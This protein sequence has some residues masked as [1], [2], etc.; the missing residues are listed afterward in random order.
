MND[1]VLKPLRLKNI[2]PNDKRQIIS[3]RTAFY[4]KNDAGKTVNG[5]YVDPSFKLAGAGFLATAE[6]LATF[7]AALIDE[8]FL[9]RKSLDELFQLGETSGGEKTPFALGFRVVKTS[10]RKEIIHQPGGGVG[11]SSVLFIDRQNKVSIAILTN[12]TGAPIG[13]LNFL[14]S[15]AD[16]FVN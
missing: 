2:L 3:N 6:D 9:K 4:I 13:N 1:F 15:I 10:D 8:G 5:E 11:I 14:R 7:G 12:Q 16:S